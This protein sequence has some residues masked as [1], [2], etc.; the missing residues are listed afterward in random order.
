MKRRPS[1]GHL[2]SLVQGSW[3]KAGFVFFF[4]LI[5]RKFCFIMSCPSGTVVKNLPAVQETWV[6][7][8][9]IPE[10]GRSP[11]EGNG[12]PLQ[13]FQQESPMDRGARCALVH[14]I[15]RDG[16]DLNTKP[17][18]PLLLWGQSKIPRG[19]SISF[20][21]SLVIVTRFMNIVFQRGYMFLLS[22]LI[23]S[24]CPPSPSHPAKEGLV[25]L[26]EFMHQFWSRIRKLDR[27]R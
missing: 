2:G 17:P 15:A 12:Y 14:G 8:G 6:H 10:S 19:P 1:E 18:P 24:S 4:F 11:G 26:I 25:V 21:F 13:Y 3:E 9:S 16:H 7:M 20:F 5:W 22:S 23:S 27:E